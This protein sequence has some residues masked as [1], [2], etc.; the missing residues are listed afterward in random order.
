MRGNWYVVVATFLILGP[1]AM[2]PLPEDLW[3]R[4]MLPIGLALGAVWQA[5]DRRDLADR[6]TLLS[7][8]IV[9]S[10]ALSLVPGLR[11]S[12]V[13]L[14]SFMGVIAG[15]VLTERFLRQREARAGHDAGSEMSE[16]T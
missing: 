11:V 12:L 5:I 9:G 16:P 6:L 8:L 2:V 14:L 7:V 4:A 1:K 13:H 3:V 15:L 10:A